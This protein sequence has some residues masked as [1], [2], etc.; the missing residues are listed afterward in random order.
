V[1]R[2]LLSRNL[3]GFAA[4]AVVA[5]FGASLAPSPVALATLGVLT[6]GSARVAAEEPITGGEGTLYMPARPGKV[7]IANEAD[8]RI[9]G[10]IPL[11][12]ASPGLSYPLQLSPD[13]KR[14]Y[15]YC[16]NLEDIEVVDIATRKVVDAIRFSQGSKK[17]RFDGYEGGALSPRF[18]ALPVRSSTK[19]I[20][21]FE[22]GSKILLEYDLV[23]RKIGRTIPWPKGEEREQAAVKYSPDGKL[24][25]VFADDVFIYDAAKLEIVDTWE[26]SRPIE[27]GFGRVQLGAG[28]EFAEEPGFVTGLFNV[29]DPVEHRKVMGIARVDLARKAMDFWTVGPALPLRKFALAPG[30]KKAYALLDEIGHYEIWTFDLEGRRLEKRTPFAGRP[31]MDLAVSSNGKLLYVFGAGNTIDVFDAGTHAFVRTVTLDAEVS[32]VYVFPPGR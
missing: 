24:F 22:I 3:A 18:L 15:S 27:E 29:E 19:L 8:F 12:K 30:R 2:F 1:T 6:A 5:V 21:R 17:I 28:D 23:A 4:A 7:L 9:T 16:S 32:Q 10:E 20:D 31:R 14:F 13:R 25:Y 11:P 26:L